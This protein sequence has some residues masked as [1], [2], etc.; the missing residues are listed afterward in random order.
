MTNTNKKMIAKRAQERA[1]TASPYVGET[2]MRRSTIIACCFVVASAAPILA[3][4]VVSM[5]NEGAD[6]FLH[7]NHNRSTVVATDDT[8]EPV[9]KYLYNYFGI[10]TV[11]D[12]QG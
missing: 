12:A 1:R 10:T 3:Q 8:G 2:D 7:Y 6:Y 4:P 9:E 11:L 5:E